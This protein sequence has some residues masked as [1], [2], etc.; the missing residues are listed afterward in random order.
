[1]IKDS[2]HDILDGVDLPTDAEV[3]KETHNARY[4]EIN[5]K[6]AKDKNSNWYKAN[7]EANRKKAQDPKWLEANRKGQAN[8]DFEAYGK[9]MQEWWASEESATHR[10]K[11]VSRT[12]KMGRKNAKLIMTPDGEFPSLTKAA[13]FYG[14]TKGSMSTRMKYYPEKYYYIEQS[15]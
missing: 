12:Q 10:E 15:T 1:M 4:A 3:R 6:R 7:A 9:K 2:F 14:I 13:E 11:H 8:K 5:K